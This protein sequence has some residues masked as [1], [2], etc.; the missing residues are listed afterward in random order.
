MKG[1]RTGRIVD[2]V[3]DMGEHTPAIVTQVMNK[4]EGI[5]YLTLFPPRRNPKPLPFLTT[6]SAEPARHSWHW[7]EFEE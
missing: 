3:S 5:V 1:L 4:E 2:Y 7:L 6:Y